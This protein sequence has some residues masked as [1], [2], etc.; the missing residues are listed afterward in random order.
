[1]TSLTKLLA[2]NMREQRRILGISQAT[3]A[4]RVNTSTH[5]IAMIELERKTPSLPMIERIAEALEIDAPELFSMKSIPIES[6]K[7][8]HG[9]VLGFF[10]SSFAS[11]INEVKKGKDPDQVIKD[12]LKKRF[13]D[14][15]PGEEK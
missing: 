9:A 6:L 3:L 11:I 14:S 8:L 4:E 2:M 7:G 1:M 10:G 13:P 12:T 15:P 5:Y